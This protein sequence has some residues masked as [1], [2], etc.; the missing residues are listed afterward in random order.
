MPTHLELADWDRRH[1]WHAFTQMAEYE[2][3]I[4]QRASGCHLIDIHGQAYL[5]GVSS[6]WCVVRRWA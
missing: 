1:F 5:D 4:I 6:M 3:L 2:P